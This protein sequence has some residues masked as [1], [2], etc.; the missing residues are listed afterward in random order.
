MIL[1]RWL[2]P[3]YDWILDLLIKVGGRGWSYQLIVIL[4]EKSGI[5]LLT[6]AYK[7]LGILNGGT[8]EHS[9]EEYVVANVLPEYVMTED[10]AFFDVGAHV[11]GYSKMLKRYYPSSVIHAFEPNPKV[12]KKLQAAFDDSEVKCNKLG[13]GSANKSRVLYRFVDNDKSELSSSNAEAITNLDGYSGKIEKVPFRTTTLD[14]YCTKH[15]V[16]RIDFL[17]IDVEGGELDVIR[18]ASKLI[19][20]GKIRLIQFEFNEHNLFNRVILKDFFD[21][22]RE[23]DIFRVKKDCLIP[24]KKYSTRDEIFCY[25][26]LLAVR[27]TKSRDSR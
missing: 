14:H 12:F 6:L 10:P 20:K 8:F 3:V 25:Q 9:G 15:V 23:Y 1:L 2:K 26:N 24:L 21:V 22:L 18:G 16:S 13:L 19:S 27:R 5:D 4:A 11:G 7:Q 17:K